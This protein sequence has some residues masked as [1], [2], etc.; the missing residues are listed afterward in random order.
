MKTKI[1]VVLSLFIITTFFS[2][3]Y[4]SRDLEPIEISS[5]LISLGVGESDVLEILGM[6]YRE[7]A[8]DIEVYADNKN[9]VSVT[10]REDNKYIYDVYAL[11]IGETTIH[12]NLYGGYYE[13]SEGNSKKREDKYFECKITIT[14]GQLISSDYWGTWIQMDTGDEFY[15]DSDTLFEIDG[16][17]NGEP[18][19]REL[20]TGILGYELESENV[21]KKGSTVFFRK[22]GKN[23]S[24]SLSLSGFSDS[25]GRVSRAASSGITNVGRENLRNPADSEQI[26]IS[27]NTTVSM[28]GGV[29]GDPQSVTVSDGDNTGTA[30]VNP[31]FDGEYIGTIPIVENSKYAFKTTYEV[32]NLDDIG[33]MFGNYWAW[34][35]V[36]FDLTNIGTEICSTSIYNISWD[37]TNLKTKDF[38]IDG[39]FSSIEPGKSKQINGKFLYGFFDDSEY[40]DVIVKIE[41]TDSTYMTTWVDYVTFRFYKEMVT[42]NVNARNFNTNSNATLKGFLIYP[43]KRSKRFTVKN[44]T[45]VTMP[46]SESNYYIVLSGATSDNEMCYS[47]AFKDEAS[48]ADLSGTWQL[49]EINAYEPNDNMNRAYRV[50]DLTVPIKAYLKNND[51]DYYVINTSGLTYTEDAIETLE[52]VKIPDQN[53]EISKTPVTQGVYENIMGENPSYFPGVNNPIETV[54]WYDAI[55]FCNKLSQSQGYEPVYYVNGNRYVTNW[56]YTPHVDDSIEGEITQNLSANGYRLPSKDEWIFAA[57]GGEDFIYSGSDDIDKVAWYDDNSE[58][59][60]HPVARK[61]ANG[62]GLYDMSG[63]VWEWCWD[64]YSSTRRYHMGGAYCNDYGYAKLSYTGYNYADDRYR[65]WGFRVARSVTE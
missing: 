22:G 61:L 47:F 26:T 10:Q 45:T 49:S 62:Y 36:T 19:L 27:E 24:F 44:N 55:Y 41:I 53:F 2:S 57:K 7:N 38:A 8:Y 6:T 5:T 1:M 33:F 9:I 35:D 18:R 20:Q 17:S 48:L 16:Y 37:D 34:Y 59:K 65:S 43:D 25:I 15:I 12:V 58:D 60:T 54:N 3:C 64:A 46:W 21:L 52:M 4:E 42:L 56:N 32:S 50:S 11:K 39:N 40:K 63:N 28:K 23:R 13:D 29:A 30:V 31:K 51:L 14:K